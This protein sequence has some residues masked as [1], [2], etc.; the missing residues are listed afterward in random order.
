[1]DTV[2]TQSTMQ[3]A[4]Y[5]PKRRPFCQG[6]HCVRVKRHTSEETTTKRG[7]ETAKANKETLD[8]LD[9]TYPSATDATR[10]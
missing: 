8:D 10:N 9:N 1:M 2:D 4:V 5:K 6:R 7:E 3:K